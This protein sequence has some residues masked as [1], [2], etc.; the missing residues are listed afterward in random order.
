[1]SG[2]GNAIGFDMGGTSCDVC[3][4]EQGEV[5][6]HRLATDRG[7]GDR[8]ADGRRAHGRR[9]GGSI[10]WRD[11]GGA[12]RVGPQVSRRRSR[13]RLLRPRRCREPTVTD[14]NLELGYLA[15]ERATRRRRSSSMQHAGRAA[16]ARLGDSLGLDPLESAEGI[17][18]VANQEMVRACA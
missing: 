18:R 7:E 17:I 15:A 11:S 5:R 4:I 10:A 2:D 1:M 6:P 16:L 14:A 12:L 13:P 8:A 9:G 3:V